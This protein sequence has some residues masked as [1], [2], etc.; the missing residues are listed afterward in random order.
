[1]APSPSATAINAFLRQPV[2][3]E[4]TAEEADDALLGLVSHVGEAELDA[5]EEEFTDPGP[6][7]PT[8]APG[9]SAIPPLHLSV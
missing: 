6:P 2:T 8:L 3:E 4:S 1:M 5:I 7:A 9:P